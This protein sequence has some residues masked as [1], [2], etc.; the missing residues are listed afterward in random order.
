M[1]NF[2]GRKL[3]TLALAAL[4]AL[5]SP[6]FAAD[7]PPRTRRRA[8]R[9]PSSRRESLLLSNIVEVTGIL[10]PRDETTVRPERPGLKVAEVLVEPGDTVTAGQLLARL[11]LPKADRSRC[12]RRWPDW[13]AVPPR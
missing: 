3:P 9:S 11:T 10:I 13:S 5:A 6:A 4:L 7:E 2:P 1:I 12:R 8:P